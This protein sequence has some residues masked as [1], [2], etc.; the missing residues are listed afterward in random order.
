MVAIPFDVCTILKM[1]S[2]WNKSLFRYFFFSFI[3]IYLHFVI[4]MNFLSTNSQILST[5]KK[6]EIHIREKNWS[7][8]KFEDWI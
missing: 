3:K 5:V 8:E 2:K 7:I 4:I 6:I 1:K